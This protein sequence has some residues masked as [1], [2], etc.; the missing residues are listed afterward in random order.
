MSVPGR[1]V[2]AD[3]YLLQI[4]ASDHN[5]FVHAPVQGN[6]VS[7]CQA[8]HLQLPLTSFLGLCQLFLQ[9]D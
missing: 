1:S 4:K 8:F 7:C 3:W 9:K 2:S 6:K 5:T